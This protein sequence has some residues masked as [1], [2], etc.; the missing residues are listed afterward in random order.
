M[1]NQN[2]GQYQNPEYQNQ[3]HEHQNQNADQQH[4]NVFL[5]N[6]WF[7]FTTRTNQRACTRPGQTFPSSPPP[8]GSVLIR[9]P[10]AEDPVWLR[11]GS[12]T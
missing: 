2:P 6:F 5:Q 3:K 10:S 4:Y 11:T 7:S 12:R 1:Q 8:G 9:P